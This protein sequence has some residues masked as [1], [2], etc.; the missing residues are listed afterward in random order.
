ML[1][2]YS[3]TSQGLRPKERAS[4]EG[5]NEQP[6]SPALGALTALWEVEPPGNAGKCCP[7]VT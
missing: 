4:L 5:S 7:G 1:G 6:L 3:T 2:N